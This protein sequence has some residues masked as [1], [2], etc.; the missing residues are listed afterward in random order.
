M[1]TTAVKKE[2]FQ[3]A[4]LLVMT[5]EAD[6][7]ACDLLHVYRINRG[8]IL[9]WSPLRD[10]IR[11]SDGEGYDVVAGPFTSVYIADGALMITG[12]NINPTI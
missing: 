6:F 5:G 1:P 4:L 10:A 12:K 7:V 11:P 2:N 9:R 8:T 3:S